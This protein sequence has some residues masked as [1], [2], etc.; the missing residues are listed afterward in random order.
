MQNIGTAP[1]MQIWGAG[2]RGVHQQ[3]QIAGRPYRER[4][5]EIPPS[6]RGNLRDRL[7]KLTG[8][9]GETNRIGW[10]N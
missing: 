10:G 8:Q 5:G 6:Q 9:A 4:T 7:G 3:E 2:G 1:R